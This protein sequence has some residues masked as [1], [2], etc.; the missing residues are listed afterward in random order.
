MPPVVS[1]AEPTNVERLAIIVVVSV[2]PFGRTAN[3][4]GATDDVA[5]FDRV[6]D[7]IDGPD[8]HVVS[9]AGAR[10]TALPVTVGT[11]KSLAAIRANLD[12]NCARHAG[13]VRLVSDTISKSL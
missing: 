9:S 4:T 3:F 7:L 13:P 2:D 11:W 1:P 5:K 8:L 6:V 10:N 12:W